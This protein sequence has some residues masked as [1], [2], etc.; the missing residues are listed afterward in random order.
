MIRHSTPLEVLRRCEIIGQTMKPKPECRCNFRRIARHLCPLHIDMEGCVEER[1]LTVRPLDGLHDAALTRFL[2]EKAEGIIHHPPL[3]TH[4]N[5]E[6]IHRFELNVIRET[7][8]AEHHGERANAALSKLCIGQCMRNLYPRIC[9]NPRLLDENSLRIYENRTTATN[10]PL[11][12]ARYRNF[13]DDPNIAQGICTHGDGCVEA[14]RR[15]SADLHG[16][17]K[18]GNHRGVYNRF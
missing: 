1:V 7:E 3:N 6:R 18:H 10:A 11:C 4:A 2:D 13:L 5:G 16:L 14:A 17:T 12:V 9:K 15:I 8:F